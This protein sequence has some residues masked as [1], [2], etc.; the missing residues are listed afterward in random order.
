M[1]PSRSDDPHRQ[2]VGLVSP[3]S[4]A[5]NLRCVSLICAIS[6]GVGMIRERGLTVC[7][8]PS[9]SPQ[10]ASTQRRTHSAP[11]ESIVSR[12][13]SPRNAFSRD[14][15]MSV[16]YPRSR[17]CSYSG[18]SRDHRPYTQDSKPGLLALANIYLGGRFF[19]V[20]SRC[21]PPAGHPPT[22]VAC[23]HP[24]TRASSTP[25]ASSSSSSI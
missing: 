7:S 18:E 16:E 25:Q 15:L 21:F 17:Q 20:A 1:L 19:P 12:F 4:R 14:E 23:D 9:T 3:W 22:R 8:W 10:A 5:R 24:P 2:Q 6:S 11:F 13:A